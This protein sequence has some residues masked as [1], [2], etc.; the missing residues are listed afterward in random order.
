[1]AMPDDESAHPSLTRAAKHQEELDKLGR[2]WFADLREQAERDEAEVQAWRR[3]HN[4]WSAFNRR[5]KF[6]TDFE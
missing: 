5:P 1:M 6:P 3:E 4:K 2:S